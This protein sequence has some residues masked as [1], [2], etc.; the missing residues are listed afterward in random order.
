MLFS[1]TPGMTK[2]STI[3][4]TITVSLDY[5]F[6]VLHYNWGHACLIN[7]YNMSCSVFSYILPYFKV[8]FSVLKGRASQNFFILS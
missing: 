5:H 3:S 2:A 6:S 1:K 8:F 4:I 7:A